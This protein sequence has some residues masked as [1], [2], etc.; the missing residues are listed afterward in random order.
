M[1][2]Q[3]PNDGKNMHSKHLAAQKLDVRQL[4]IKPVCSKFQVLYA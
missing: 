2:I 4:E 1:T 3:L